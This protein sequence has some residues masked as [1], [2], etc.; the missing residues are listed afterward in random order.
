MAAF[1]YLCIMQRI[2]SNKYQRSNEIKPCSVNQF[3]KLTRNSRMFS[4]LVNCRTVCNAEE[5][6]FQYRL[7]QNTLRKAYGYSCRK[8]TAAHQ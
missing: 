2:M 3:P 4:T 7:A 1:L 6:L 5:N 8:T